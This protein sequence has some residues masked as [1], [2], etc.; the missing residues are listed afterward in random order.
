[1]ISLSLKCQIFIL[2][3]PLVI[4]CG[5]CSTT[6]IVTKEDVLKVQEGKTTKQELVS[7]L[8]LPEQTGVEGD[9]EWWVYYKATGETHTILGSLSYH[10]TNV[11]NPNLL[12]LIWL[13]KTGV[14]I[15]VLHGGG[16][17]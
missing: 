11:S 7:L 14:V 13:D 17:K 16:A 1:M 8:G 10:Q 5:S 6:R 12:A 2:V 15:K 9:R 3:I 4:L